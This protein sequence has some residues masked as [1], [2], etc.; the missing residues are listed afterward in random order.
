MNFFFPPTPFIF[1]FPLLVLTEHYHLYS[2]P[3]FLRRIFPFC[4]PPYLEFGIGG[5]FGHDPWVGGP[6]SPFCGTPSFFS[7]CVITPSSFCWTPPFNIG[8]FLHLYDNCRDEQVYSS[9]GIL[10]TTLPVPGAAL[11]EPINQDVL[12]FAFPR[13]ELSL[14]CGFTLFGTCKGRE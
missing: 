13:I 4:V 8:F 3:F 7:R 10:R 1:F 6:L 2:S 14:A 11:A 9:R 5:C 12:P